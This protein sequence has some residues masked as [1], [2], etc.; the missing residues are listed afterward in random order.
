MAAGESSD[1]ASK[2]LAAAIAAGSPPPAASNSPST[3]LD[4]VA[5]SEPED[6]NVN[7]AT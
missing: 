3:V 2:P 7:S 1:M 5:V 4:W 6:S